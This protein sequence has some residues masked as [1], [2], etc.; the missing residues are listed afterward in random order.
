M[1]DMDKNPDF[2]GKTIVLTKKYERVIFAAQK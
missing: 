1:L 2:S